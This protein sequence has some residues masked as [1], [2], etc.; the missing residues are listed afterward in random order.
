MSIIR[1]MDNICVDKGA[2][3]LQRCSNPIYDCVYLTEHM[4]HK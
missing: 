1:N 4:E 2:N 3:A